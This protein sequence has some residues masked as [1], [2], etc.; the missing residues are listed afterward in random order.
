M[1]T[2]FVES[3]HTVIIVT[4]YFMYSETCLNRTLLGL[5]Y[6]FGILID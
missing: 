4:R 2:N 3:T 5:T 1:C 6:V